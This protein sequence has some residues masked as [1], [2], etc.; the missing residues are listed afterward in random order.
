MPRKSSAKPL[1]LWATAIVVAIVLV[2]GILELTNT[3]HWFRDQK[4][5]SGTIPAIHQT[6]KPSTNT[7][8]NRNQS[9]PTGAGSGSSS[10][11]ISST[12]PSSSTSQQKTAPQG[13]APITPYGNFVSNHNP[14]LSGSLSNEESVC[15]TTPGAI[16]YITFT[17]NGVIKKLPAET[18]DSN[19]SVFWTWNVGS[20]GFT[21]GNWQI[22]AYATLNEQTVSAQDKIE[23]NVQ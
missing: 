4:A 9:S 3:I 13:P 19:G 21:T 2:I 14:T 16:C 11:S 18:A 8:Q 6:A 17:Q 7:K 1:I 23:L 5:T 10:G 12:S 22:T 20:A 15:N